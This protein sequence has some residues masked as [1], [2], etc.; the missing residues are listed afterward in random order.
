MGG[1]NPPNVR[2]IPSLPPARRLAAAASLACALAPLAFAQDVA[3][4]GKPMVEYTRRAV[5]A[6]ESADAPALGLVVQRPGEPPVVAVTGLRSATGDIAVSPEDAWHWGSI[7][8]SITATLVARLVDQG[9]VGWDDAAG[10]L[11]AEV[12]PEMR[13]AFAFAT[14]RHLLS[15]RSGMQAN[16]PVVRFSEFPQAPEDPVEDRARWIRIALDQEPV[17]EL[18]AV[19]HYSND[20]YIVAGAMLEAATGESW[21]TLMRREVFE[22]LGLEGAGFGAPNGKGPYD[23]PRGHRPSDGGDRPQGRTA[24]NPAALGPA[25]RVHMPLA[26]MARYLRVHAERDEE[27][28][29]AESWETLHTKPFGGN[30]ALGWVVPDDVARWH[31]GSNGS[32]YAEAAFNLETGVVAAVVV[33]DGAIG[34]VQAAVSGLMGFLLKGED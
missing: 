20:G 23:Q 10:D 26:D 17:G 29:S 8:K 34:E 4:D 32:W 12:A 5:A 30:Y 25:G 7:S 6:R 14:F 21:E 33:N 18:E 24:D 11:L 15:H 3:P 2:E 1:M 13:E 9:V 16:I 19:Y 27:F 22:P 31:N 28:L